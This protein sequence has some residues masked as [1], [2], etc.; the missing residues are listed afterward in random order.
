MWPDPENGVG[1]QE[2]GSPRRPVSSGMK[3]SGESKYCSVR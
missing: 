1:D 3:V 2:T